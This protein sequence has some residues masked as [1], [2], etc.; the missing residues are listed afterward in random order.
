V[1]GKTGRNFAAGM[2][3]GIAFVLDEDGDFATRC[4]SSMVDLSPVSDPAEI[5]A[6]YQ[7][8]KKHADLTRSQKAFKVLA[9]WEEQS[10]RQFVRVMPRD[11]ARVLKALAKAEADGLT[12]DDALIAAFESNAKD[13]ARVGGG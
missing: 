2:S 6:L 3:G 12:G 4:N 11:Y 9:L 1:L 10:L 7:L 8:I 5:E 13:A